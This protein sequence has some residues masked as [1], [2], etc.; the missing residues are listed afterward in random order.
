MNYHSLHDLYLRELR[1]LL[2]AGKQMARAL[3]KIIRHTSA[4]SL[5]R[6]L[7]SQLEEMHSRNSRLEDLL[8]GHHRNGRNACSRGMEGMIEEIDEWLEE[9]ATA[10]VMDAGII[11][12]IQRSRHYGIAGYG[13]ARTYAALLGQSRDESLLADLLEEEREADS[14]LTQEARRINASANL[15][16]G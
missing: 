11:G 4:P 2:S 14:A 3:P 13:C 10:E 1:D 16:V 15:P 12:L 8:E 5:R 6:A 9:E 7:E